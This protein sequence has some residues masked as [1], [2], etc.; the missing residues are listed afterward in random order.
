MAC[1]SPYVTEIRLKVTLKRHKWWIFWSTLDSVDT[2]WHDAHALSTAVNG[3]CTSGEHT[4][5]VSS[6][7]KARTLFGS[8]SS[9]DSS[10]GRLNC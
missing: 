5:K 1:T 2:G 6:N 3:T 10:Q 4:Y 9:S 7:G 8:G